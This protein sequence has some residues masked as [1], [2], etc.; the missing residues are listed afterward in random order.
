MEIR[1]RDGRAPLEIKAETI[2]KAVEKVAEK[3]VDL[4]RRKG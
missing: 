4:A 2:K 1:Y 3:I